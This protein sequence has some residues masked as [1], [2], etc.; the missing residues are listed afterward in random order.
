MLLLQNSKTSSSW[1]AY[2]KHSTI[3]TMMMAS[4][5]V[6]VQVACLMLRSHLFIWSVFSPKYLYMMAWT[7]GQHLGVNVLLSSAVY[8][9]ATST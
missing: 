2:F 5:L 8:W 4:N 3:L 1:Q 6:F 7:L 9:A